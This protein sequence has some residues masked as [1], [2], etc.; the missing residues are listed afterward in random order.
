MSQLWREKNDYTKFDPEIHDIYDTCGYYSFSDF[1][2]YNRLYKTLNHNELL[3]LI[4]DAKA[5]SWQALDLSDCGL[6]YLPDELWNLPDLQML[7]LGSQSFEE[8]DEVDEIN[9]MNINFL[10][11]PTKIERLQSLQVL[12]LSGSAME[13][14]DDIPLNMPQLIHLDIFECGFPQIPKALLIPSLKGVSFN[15]LDKFLSE[16]FLKLENLDIIDLSFSDIENLPK[17]MDCFKKLQ[18]LDLWSTKITALPDSMSKLRYLSEL[19]LGNTP[20]AEKIPPEILNQ[21]AKE[22]VRYALAQQSDAPKEY[23]NESKM[24]IVGQGSVG[25]SSL[26][27][28]LI[29]NKYTDGASTEGIDITNWHFSENE[30]FYKLNVWDFGGQE[31]YHSTHQ[32]FLTERSL[33]LLVWDVLAEEEYGRIDYWLKTIQSLA[34]DSPI[35]IVVNKCDNNIGRINHLDDTDYKE[36]FPQI[37]DIVYVSCKDNIGIEDLRK[38]IKELAINLPLMKTSWLSSWLNVRKRLEELSK[39]LN[40]ISYEKYLKICREDNIDSEEALS[41]IKYLHDLGIVLYYHND[42]LLSNIVILSSEWGTD[43]VYKV[44]DEQEKQLKGRNGIL[45][46]DDLPIIW[47]DKERYPKERYQYL[48]NLMKRFQLAFEVS[49]ST[50]LVAELLE[51]K[52]INLDYEFPFGETLSFRYEYDFIP[53]GIMTRFIVSLNNYLETID[54]VKQC[55]KKGAYLKRYTAYALVRLYDNLSERYV[56]IKVSGE[57]SRERQELLTIIRKSFEEIHSQFKQI[58]IIEK[59]PCICSEECKFLFEYKSILRAERKGKSTIECHHTLEDV[60]IKKLLDGVESNMENTKLNLTI[61]N[62]PQ[63]NP[64]FNYSP[65]NNVTQNPTNTSTS[66]SSAENTV[67]TT[68]TTTITVDIRNAINGLQGDFNDLKDEANGKSQEFDKDCEKVTSALNKLDTCETK[69][70]IIK[71]GAM[72]KIERFLLECSDPQSKTG[73]LLAGVKY[74]GGIVKDITCKYNSIAKWVGFP[75]VPFVGE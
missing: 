46:C 47:N 38:L 42:S 8:V 50:Y 14:E 73:K 28:R 40:F 63:I 19:E 39:T 45:C 11:I 5:F 35:I 15:C 59:I 37:K 57:I 32:F 7:Y 52:T 67:T 10:L 43:A 48:L 25:K 27:K 44:L 49:N 1:I 30:K 58:K 53:A 41:L 34:G 70:D 18:K 74:A 2:P 36:R 17:H 60:N 65:Q 23:F 64:K 71:S 31:I 24:V 29:W 4:S 61:H 33:Y 6:T 9:E 51:N 3:Q 68:V 56:D 62:N 16:D 26:L 12:N 72:K 20:L 22:I 54:N 69:E 21:S 55:W 75:L 13:F 66:T